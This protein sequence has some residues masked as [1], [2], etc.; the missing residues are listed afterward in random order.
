MTTVPGV[1]VT[2]ARIREASGKTE[3]MGGECGTFPA[4]RPVQRRARTTTPEQR[5]NRQR[6]TTDDQHPG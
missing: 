4:Q 6:G 2:A 1:N 3:S 5:P